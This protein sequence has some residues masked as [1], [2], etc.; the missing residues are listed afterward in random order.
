M[1][2]A[3]D[4]TLLVVVVT[5]LEMCLGVSVPAG[6]CANCEHALT[7]TL[8]E[9]RDQRRPVHWW[10][11]LFAPPGGLARVTY[12]RHCC[13]LC[14]ALGFSDPASATEAVT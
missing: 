7:L 3:F 4:G 12:L 11:T 6:H 13:H 8:F 5:L 14:W 2:L 10:P 1:P 9:I